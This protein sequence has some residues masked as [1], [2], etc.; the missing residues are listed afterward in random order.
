MR[1]DTIVTMTTVWRA[2]PLLLCG[3]VHRVHDEAQGLGDLLGPHRVLLELG[4]HRRLGDA[5]L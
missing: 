5:L 3:H 2:L 1:P 4:L